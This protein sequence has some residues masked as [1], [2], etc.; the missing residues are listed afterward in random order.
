METNRMTPPPILDGRSRRDQDHLQ[1]LA[2]F[3][4]IVAGFAVAG[5]GFL[6]LHDAF[7]NAIFANPAMWKDQPNGSPAEFFRAIIGVFKWCYVVMTVFGVAIGTANVMSGIW[8]RKQK[9]RMFSLVVSGLNC[10]QVP[11]G[12]VLGVFTIIVLMHDS[13]HAQY[14]SATNRD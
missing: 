3:H 2:V 8:L 13:V 14:E 1:L 10:L 9:N 4:F 11:F 6:L 12:T 7:M 5:I